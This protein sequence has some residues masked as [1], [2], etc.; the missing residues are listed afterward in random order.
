MSPARAPVGALAKD[1]IMATGK[2][3][4]FFDQKGFGFIAPDDRSKHHFVHASD[5]A[6]DNM[7]LKGD[8]V[9]YH[10]SYDD[11][12]C[13]SKAV[14]VSGGTGGARKESACRQYKAGNCTYGDRCR[15]SHG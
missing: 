6:D 12:K 3:A 11:Q 9:W 4:R 5:I 10:E 7:L 13:K 8:E 14:N 2:V 15:F 1:T